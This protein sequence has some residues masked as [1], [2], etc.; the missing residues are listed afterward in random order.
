[1]EGR[2]D[3]TMGLDW[4]VSCVNVMSYNL[5][6]PSYRRPSLKRWISRFKS[7]RLKICKSYW[8]VSIRASE[9]RT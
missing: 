9:E 5:E 7:T 8:A 3:T 2:G 1:M 6:D 4:S